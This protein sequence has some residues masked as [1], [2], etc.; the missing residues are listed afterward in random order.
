M[1]A[2]Y[3][4]VQELGLSCDYTV[5]PFVRNMVRK[6]YAVPFLPPDLIDECIVEFIASESFKVAKRFYPALVTLI[7]CLHTQWYAN[8]VMPFK[9]WNV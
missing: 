5:D 7:N 3:R 9:M 4:K 6:L 2:I 1:Q 8:P